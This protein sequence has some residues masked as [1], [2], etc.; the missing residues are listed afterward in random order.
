METSRERYERKAAAQVNQWNARLG[1][2]KARAVKANAAVGVELQ[3]RIDELHALQES[4]RKHLD[5]FGAMSAGKWRVTQTGHEASWA[6]LSDEI[7][8]S[9]RRVR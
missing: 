7:E 4:A 1:I 8:A 6:K 3:K 9:W 2:L 5:E